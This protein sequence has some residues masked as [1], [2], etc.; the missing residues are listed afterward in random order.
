MRLILVGP[1]G[2]G[3]GTQSQRLSDDFNIPQLSTGELL[4]AAVAAGTDTG[5]K[6]KAVI[7]RGE[8]VPDEMVNAIVA[9]RIDEPDCGN[10]FI[11]DGYPRTLEQADALEALLKERGT[12]LDAVVKLRIDDDVMVAR[13]TG[14]Y[15][16][17]G[18]G[19][20][21]HDTMKL[22]AEPGVCDNCGKTEFKRRA[23]DNEESL[24]VRLQAYYKKTAP[25]IGYYYCKGKLRR[26]NGMN[27]ITAVGD[28]IAGILKAL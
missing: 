11:L 23:D 14:R 16:C 17:A 21:Y 13:I 25:L 19:E 20:G 22:P 5:K 26:V 2:A 28:E 24:R 8:L 9:E 27:S 1:P 15:T 6:A 3:K 18:C 7:E 10:G 4:R 12:P